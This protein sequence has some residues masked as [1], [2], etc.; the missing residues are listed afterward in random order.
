MTAQRTS[1]LDI[2]ITLW[3]EGNGRMWMS[4][5]SQGNMFF[6]LYISL[7]Q[8]STIAKN[9]SNWLLLSDDVE[10]GS[11]LLLVSYFDGTLANY[12]T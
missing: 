11:S 10:H 6:S 2:Y 12:V 1:V 7:F 8:Y 5:H 3:V 4:F 9:R